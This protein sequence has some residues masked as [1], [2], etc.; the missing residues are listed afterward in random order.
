MIDGNMIVI[1]LILPLIYAVVVGTLVYQEWVSEE[2]LVFCIGVVGPL[3]FMSLM[4]FLGW[5]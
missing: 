2:M 5:L 1:G 4:A 3:L